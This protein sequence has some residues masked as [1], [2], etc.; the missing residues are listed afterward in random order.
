M[1]Q[2]YVVDI[3]SEPGPNPERPQILKYTLN[4]SGEVVIMENGDIAIGQEVNKD[5]NKA[6]V[7]V[8]GY[9]RSETGDW[10]H[11]GDLQGRVGNNHQFSQHDLTDF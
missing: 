5:K 8:N 3:D 10:I 2:L 1:F 9:A 4:E 6:I 11:R 7:G